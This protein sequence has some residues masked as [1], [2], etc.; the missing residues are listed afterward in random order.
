M[1]TIG[2]WGQLYDHIFSLGSSVYGHV[3]RDGECHNGTTNHRKVL[4]SNFSICYKTCR[5]GGLSLNSTVER[6]ERSTF[7]S[8]YFSYFHNC[9]C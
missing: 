1:M 2:E 4:D 8:Q 9:C 7:T 6:D 3:S 5:V